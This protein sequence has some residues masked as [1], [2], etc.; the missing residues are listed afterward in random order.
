MLIS[1]VQQS[2]SVIRIYI[3]FR[4]LFHDALCVQ[5]VRSVVTHS[6]QIH[7]LQPAKLL[8]PMD[9]FRQEHWTELPFPMPVNL[10]DPGIEPESLTSPVLASRLFTTRHHLGSPIFK[11]YFFLI[12]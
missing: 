7:G 9:F 2:D 5:C 12:Y 4:I 1:A 10:P 3:I 11:N 8:S 6:L